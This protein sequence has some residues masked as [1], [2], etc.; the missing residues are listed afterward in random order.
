[1][2]MLPFVYSLSDIQL[3]LQ[4]VILNKDQ[5]CLF[6]KF[7]V[8][9]EP[10]E[11]LHAG[12]VL[13]GVYERAVPIGDARLPLH[14]LQSLSSR[15]IATPVLLPDLNR[16]SLKSVPE[17]RHERCFRRFWCVVLILG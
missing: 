1:M 14:V 4:K 12:H 16:V 10:G 11:G 7:I 13:N 9:C 8:H 17:L 6:L 3:H 2:G 5:V 15:C